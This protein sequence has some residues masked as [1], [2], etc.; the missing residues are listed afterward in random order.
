MYLEQG[1]Y[2]ETADKSQKRRIR[3]RAGSFKVVD[4]DLMYV[5]HKGN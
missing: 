5:G 4:G 1:K 2:A 3:E